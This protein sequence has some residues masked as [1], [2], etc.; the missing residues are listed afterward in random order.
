MRGQFIRL[1]LITRTLVAEHFI[2]DPLYINSFQ[3]W[4]IIKPAKSISLICP[5]SFCLKQ[6][7]LEAHLIGLFSYHLSKYTIEGN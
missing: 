4:T 7:V 5:E 1:S 2:T 6:S 3:N